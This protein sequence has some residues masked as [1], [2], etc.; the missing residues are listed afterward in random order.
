MSQTEREN[1]DGL[2]AALMGEF[3]QN[4]DWNGILALANRTL[5]TPA[6]S[7][8]LEGHQGVPEEVGDFLR[9]IAE[10]TAMRNEAMRRQ[11]EETVHALMLA[12]LEPI[13]IKGAVFL[14]DRS[15]PIDQRLFADLDL[16][17]PHSQGKAAIAALGKVGFFPYESSVGAKDGT[18]LKRTSDVGGLDLHFRLRSLPG[19]PG[20]AEILPFAISTTVGENKIPTLVPTAQAAVLIAHDQI[21]E[22]DYWRGL[23]DL[24]HLLDLDMIVR[25]HGPLDSGMLPRLFPTPASR[26]V[27]DTQ[28]LTA[29]R[30]FGTPPP[31][32]WQTDRRAKLQAQR[33]DWQLAHSAATPFLTAASLLSDLQAVTSPLAVLPDWRHRLRY[34]RRMFSKRKDTKV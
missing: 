30:L 12:G 9:H 26:R 2:C 3:P 23:I 6:L 21:Q 28:L 18:N 8:I 29:N 25:V 4:A 34:L 22:R 19:A 14:A 1:L 33:R 16:L 17:L 13:L 31:R 24:R 32:N 10:R 7:A 11:L 5:V 15:F 20:Y 27:L